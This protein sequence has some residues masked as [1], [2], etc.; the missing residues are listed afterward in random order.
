MPALMFMNIVKA[1]EDAYLEEEN[2]IE[3]L[4]S[5]ANEVYNEYCDIWSKDIKAAEDNMRM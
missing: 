3:S 4:F 2:K 1:C 5:F